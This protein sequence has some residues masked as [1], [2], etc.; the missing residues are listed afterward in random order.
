M[1]CGDDVS[2]VVFDIGSY[3]TRTGYSGEDAPRCILPSHVGV[4]VKDSIQ[5]KEQ[6]SEMVVGS[7]EL[8][9]RRD[10]LEIQSIFDDDGMLKFDLLDA[11]IEK[12]L[13]Q[14]LRVNLMETPILFTENAIH[15]KEQRMKLTEYMF[16]KYKIPALFLVKDPVLCSFSCGRSSALVLDVGH[17]A[18][19]ATPVH[20]GFALLKCIIKHNVGG[21]QLNTDLFN[22]L[23][24]KKNVDVRPRFTFKKKYVSTEGQ[25]VMQLIDLS[26]SDE[27]K[28][29]TPSFYQF[30]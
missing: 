30:N 8:G 9:H 23:K 4:L 26:Q 10:N 28:R 21:E 7:S 3:N 19:I 13:V 11:L 25:E 12:S 1:Y 27:V 2:S 15:N 16:E 14:S 24:M 17:K 5:E 22:A 18:S 29:T 20:D 6:A